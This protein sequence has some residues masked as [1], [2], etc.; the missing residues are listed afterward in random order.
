MVAPRILCDADLL[1]RLVRGL[2][3][4]VEIDE[5]EL[6]LGECTDCQQALQTLSGGGDFAA[7]ARN[8]LPPRE[9]QAQAERVK[10]NLQELPF[11]TPSED[12]RYIGKLSSYEIESV[13]GQ[14][15]FGVVLK[16]WDPSLNRFVA[17]K[18]LAS[19]L[20]HSAAAKQRFAREARA[21]A[22]VTHEAVV[23]IYAVESGGPVP[24]LVLAFVPGPS[25]DK[26]LEEHGTLEPLRVVRIAMQIA[27]GL[28][29]A[30]AQGIVHRDIKP[31]NILMSGEL[32]RIKITDF[33]L[34]SSR[35]RCEPVSERNDSWYAAVHESRAS[36]R[37]KRRSTQRSVLAGKCDVCDVLWS[38][39]L[40]S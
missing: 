20:L 16:G 4:R 22:S 15:G 8:L 27:Q 14:G 32:D 35:G 9:W 21:A 36:K 39:A 2:V 10:S 37:R 6:H 12:S 7:S 34:G 25:L 29:A 5:L 1:Q 19:P 18:V 33:G 13:L 3:S 26:Y 28:A 30:H 31:G 23:P 17:I 38:F 40:P 24:Y 11:L